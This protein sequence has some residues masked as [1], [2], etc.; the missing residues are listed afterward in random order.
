MRE[1]MPDV[2]VTNTRWATWCSC[3]RS[4]FTGSF[5]LP[6]KDHTAYKPSIVKIQ[7]GIVSQKVSIRRISPNST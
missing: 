2:F 4:D 1:R 3:K 6:E 7:K 5:P